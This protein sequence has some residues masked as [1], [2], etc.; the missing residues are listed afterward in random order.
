[1]NK[2]INIHNKNE[3]EWPQA[4]PN[5]LVNESLQII[6]DKYTNIPLPCLNLDDHTMENMD[7][8]HPAS[9]QIMK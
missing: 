7:D 8:M 5:L 2:P 3:I 1:M 9:I 4:A 6:L